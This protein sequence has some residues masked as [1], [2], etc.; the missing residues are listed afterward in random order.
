MN[1]VFD[2]F[3]KEYICEATRLALGEFERERKY[4][5][6]MPLRDYEKHISKL[7]HWLHTHPYGKAA[8]C[9]GRLVGYILFAGP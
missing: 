6:D 1:I 4:N 9:D 8:L 5:P 2:D 3:K 7:I